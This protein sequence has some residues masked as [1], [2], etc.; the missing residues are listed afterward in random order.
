VPIE[1]NE[2]DIA[3]ALPSDVSQP[4]EAAIFEAVQRYRFSGNDDP[5]DIDMTQAARRLVVKD[6][7]RFCERSNGSEDMPFEARHTENAIRIAVVLHAFRHVD[8]EQRSEGTF[9]ARMRGHEHSINEFTIRDA[10]TIRD[11]FNKHQ[12]VFRSSQQVAVEDAAWAKIDRM[13]SD[14]G[15]AGITA[16]DLYTGRRV[17]RDRLTAER[18]LE[19]FVRDGLLVPFKRKPNGAGRPTTAYRRTTLNRH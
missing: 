9:G 8:I 15:A 6:W 7:N 18:L 4:Y 16:R 17:C 12:E 3:H 11:W 2:I 13:L 5:D 10:L 1:C 14:R 19:G